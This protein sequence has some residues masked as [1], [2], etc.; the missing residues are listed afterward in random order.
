MP[1]SHGN[2]ILTWVA[3]VHG[4]V[5]NTAA[6]D[7]GVQVRGAD[8]I[9]A[10]GK[11]IR[12]EGE[13]YQRRVTAVAAA[14]HREQSGVGPALGH[15]VVDHRLDKAVPITGSRSRRLDP[16]SNVERVDGVVPTGDLGVAT[17]RAEP[18]D[19][20]TINQ[21]VAAMLDTAAQSGRSFA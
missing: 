12:R 6:L 7:Q 17:K 4:K 8:N 20:G 21:R 18:N 11:N 10:A 3:R 14:H 15:G 13:P 5:G 9:H 2:I 19:L 1:G 16:E